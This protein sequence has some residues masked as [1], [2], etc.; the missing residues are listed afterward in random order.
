MIFIILLSF[1]IKYKFGLWLI[2]ITELVKKN[3]ESTSDKE[4]AVNVQL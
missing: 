2:N 4:I 3:G 1:R